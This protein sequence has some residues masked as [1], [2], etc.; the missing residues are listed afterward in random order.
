MVLPGAGRQRDRLG[1]SGARFGLAIEEKQC[2]GPGGSPVIG[3]FRLIG[4]LLDEAQDPFGQRPRPLGLAAEQGRCGGVDQ[5]V[6]CGM[7]RG[8]PF[9]GPGR[10][11]KVAAALFLAA[12]QGAVLEK[13]ALQIEDGGLILDPGEASGVEKAPRSVEGACARVGDDGDQAA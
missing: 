4:L 12:A 10:G 9:I 6:A 3:G 13:P 8:R 2:L 7:Q 11:E 1:E 5:R